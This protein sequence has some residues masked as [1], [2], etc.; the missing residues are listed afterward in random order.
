MI[1][2][3]GVGD[4]QHL[5]GTP[6]LPD[7]PA[8]TGQLDDLVLMLALAKATELQAHLRRRVRTPMISRRDPISR[9]LSSR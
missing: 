6:L 3:G 7:T 1:H 8:P 9:L 4:Q 5:R 2:L